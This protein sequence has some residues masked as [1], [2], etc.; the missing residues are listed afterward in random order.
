MGMADY[1]LGSRFRIGGV[2]MTPELQQKI[3]TAA[4]QAVVRYLEVMDKRTVREAIEIYLK[5]K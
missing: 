3:H 2:A 1:G 4:V 5:G